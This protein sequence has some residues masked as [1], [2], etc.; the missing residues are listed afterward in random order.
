MET[1]QTTADLQAELEAA[2]AEIRRL[3]DITEAL[4]RA[5]SQYGLGVVIVDGQQILYAN[6]AFVELA[7][8]PLEE[9]LVLPSFFGLIPETERA[10]LAERMRM[11]LMGEQV[12][13]HYTT[14]FNHRHGHLVTVEAVVQVA[15]L[16]D[17]PHI[18][19]ILK[20]ITS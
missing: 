19:A 9:L 20:D 17:R 15:Y 11:R 5:Q 18:V 2:R 16:D 3:T 10:L 1:M 4:M 12:D 13:S 7:G 8:Y 14:V 6:E